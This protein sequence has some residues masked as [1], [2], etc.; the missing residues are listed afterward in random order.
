MFTL[1][2]LFLIS[3]AV[4][5]WSNGGSEEHADRFRRRVPHIVGSLFI[6]SSFFFWGWVKF[7]P[8]DF[9]INFI[10]DL[11]KD[12]AIGLIG[13]IFN[14]LGDAQISRL[15]S[16]VTSIGS[17]PGWLLLIFIPTGQIFLRTLLL[18]IGLFSVL[19]LV[20][21]PL[22]VVLAYSKIV[23]FINIALGSVAAGQAVSIF[24]L[25]PTI[26]SWGSAG[27]EW[28]GFLALVLGV[29]MGSGVWITWFGL[30]LIAVGNFIDKS[31]YMESDSS[32]L[33]Q[34]ESSPYTTTTLYSR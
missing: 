6:F 32:G 25:L 18:T 17:L 14:L 13:W 34:E 9:A 7:A 26:D 23:R 30:L 1:L 11:F 33:Y 27:T 22:S 19:Y 10:P 31:A 12:S 5:V 3:A 24:Y 4:I 28:P 8:L 21:A 20:W 16:W 29:Q 15:I 2:I